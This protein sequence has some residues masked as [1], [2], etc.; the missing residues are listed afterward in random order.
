MWFWKYVVFYIFLINY[1][2]NKQKF[3]LLEKNLLNDFIKSSLVFL[4]LFIVV[5][6]KNVLLLANVSFSILLG[7]IIILITLC[8]HW[9]QLEEGHESNDT[10]LL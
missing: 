1:V 9:F 8:R 2:E 6:K 5:N 10:D 4:C 3:T 7:T